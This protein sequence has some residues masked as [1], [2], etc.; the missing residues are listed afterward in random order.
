[1]KPSISSINI[2]RKPKAI[3][4]RTNKKDVSMIL[5]NI[6]SEVLFESTSEEWP[7]LSKYEK[8]YTKFDEGHNL[9]HMKRVRKRAIKLSEKYA[10]DKVKIAYIAATLHDIGLSKGRK[11]HEIEGAKL[12]SKDPYLKKILSSDELKEVVH[13][14][15]QHRASTG[16]PKSEI[17]KIISDAD[18]SATTTSYSLYRAIAFG[19]ANIPNKDL[20]WYIERAVNHISD[21]YK[22]RGYGRR[23]YYPETEKMMGKIYDIIPKTYNSKGVDGVWKLLTPTHQKKIKKINK[24]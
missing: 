20:K 4:T 15:A 12:I 8:M 16:K 2:F 7:D 11:N 23:V 17:A 21:K 6:P 14:V 10:P 5:N 9:E 3:Q 22:K 13:S 24:R 18:R 19:I 1:M